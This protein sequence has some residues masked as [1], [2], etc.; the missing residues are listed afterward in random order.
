MKT[1]LISTI[2]L[3][4]S[5]FCSNGQNFISAGQTEGENIFFVEFEPPLVATVDYQ[6]HDSISLDIDLDGVIDMVFHIN[7]EVRG[8]YIF[9]SWVELI[10]DSLFVIQSQNYA[11][12]A[13]KLDEGHF[14]DDKQDWIKG[15]NNHNVM[16]RYKR[17]NFMIYPY[18]IIYIG[19]IWGLGYMG[20]KYKKSYET[21]YGWIRL[22][23]AETEIHVIKFATRGLTVGTNKITSSTR[24]RFYPN[25]VHSHISIELDEPLKNGSFIEIIDARGMLLLTKQITDYEPRFTIDVSHL[26]AGFFL[27]KLIEKNEVVSYRKFLKIKK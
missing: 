9:T 7:V 25:P 21:Y 19:D 12:Y 14:I 15:D 2:F 1:L 18:D 24:F 20:I 16:I 26:D 22:I 13:R 5:I 6:H 11:N 8:D 23:P 27:M 4:G 10:S 3:F 17:Y